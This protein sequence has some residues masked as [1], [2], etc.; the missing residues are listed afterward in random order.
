M[1]MS[2]A[3]YEFHPF[4][5][6]VT[7]A[8][9]PIPAKAGWPFPRGI[10]ISFSHLELYVFN[11]RTHV[12]RAQVESLE[13]GPGFIRIRWLTG[14]AIINSVTGMDEIRRAFV[15]AGYRFDE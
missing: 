7:K 11:L 3:R 14:T 9:F 12:A 5:I 6:G 2:E 4:S 15:A 10:T 13:R 8:D 1:Q